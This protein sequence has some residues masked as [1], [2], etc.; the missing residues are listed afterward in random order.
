[1]ALLEQRDRKFSKVAARRRAKIHASNQKEEAQTAGA[2][3]YV[4]TRGAIRRW[5]LLVTVRDRHFRSWDDS[6][7]HC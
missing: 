6:L 5:I 3:L 7:G 2:V 1:M 4:H